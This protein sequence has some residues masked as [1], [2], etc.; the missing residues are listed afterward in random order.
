MCFSAGCG[1]GIFRSGVIKKTGGQKTDNLAFLSSRLKTVSVRIKLID[2][3][4][5]R[6][7]TVSWQARSCFRILCCL[8]FSLKLVNPLIDSAAHTQDNNADE[9]DDQAGTHQ[10]RAAESRHRMIVRSDVH[11]FY[12]QQVVIQ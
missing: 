7:G 1:I 8:F 10:C 4:Q 6:S 12:H 3:F 9:A 2:V 5:R 11:G